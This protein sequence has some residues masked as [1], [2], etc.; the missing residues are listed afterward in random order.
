M[1]ITAENVG[2][3][4]G[5]LASIVRVA[6][7]PEDLVSDNAKIIN[8]TLSEASGVVSENGSL[9]NVGV[10]ILNLAGLHCVYD[11]ITTCSL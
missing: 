4:V 11:I 10:R 7:A 3:I 5:E 2:P 1:V 6:A 8:S 9:T